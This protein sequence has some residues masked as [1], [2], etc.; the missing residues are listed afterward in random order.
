M[1]ETAGIFE[2]YKRNYFFVTLVAVFFLSRMLLPGIRGVLRAENDVLFVLVGMLFCV[3]LPNVLFFVAL[4][5]RFPDRKIAALGAGSFFGRCG[6]AR[7]AF[8]VALGCV[9]AFAATLLVDCAISL[10]SGLADDA[11]LVPVASG[12]PD[13]WGVCAILLFDVLLC[14]FAEELFY[15]STFREAFGTSGFWLAYAVAVFALAHDNAADAFGA[16]CVGSAAML[17]LCQS[18]SLF[19]AMCAH[20]VYNLFAALSAA[21]IDFSWS[22]YALMQKSTMAEEMIAHGLL[23]GAAGVALLAVSLIGILLVGA[24]APRAEPASLPV[25]VDATNKIKY[26]LFLLFE[27]GWFALMLFR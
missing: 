21:Y 27:A 6:R 18:G 11:S 2:K 24:H 9:A 17:L 5:N 4:A 19:A 20:G 10:A 7:L 22:A 25:R 23:V 26:L 8:F 15:R 16:L 12:T 1:S 13:F 3:L 14:A